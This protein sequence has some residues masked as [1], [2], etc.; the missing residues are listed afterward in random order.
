MKFIIGA[1][2]LLVSFELWREAGIAQDCAWRPHEW[3]I[4]TTH[5]TSI[6]EAIWRSK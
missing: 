4:T 3:W 5:C 2:L 1:V 6:P